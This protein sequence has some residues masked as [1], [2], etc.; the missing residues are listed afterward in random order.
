MK[1]LMF[2]IG[3]GLKNTL[4]EILHKPSLIIAY[5]VM[6]LALIGMVVMCIAMPVERNASPEYAALT[7]GALRVVTLALLLWFIY[8]GTK[9]GTTLFSMADVN[10]LFTSPVPSKSILI[11]GLLQ[12]AGA[13]LLVGALMLFNLVNFQNLLGIGPGQALA[14]IAVAIVYLFLMQLVQMLVYI[15]SATH[16][17]MRRVFRGAIN[18]ALLAVVLLAGWEVYAKGDLTAGLMGALASPVFGLIPVSG[19]FG[20]VA[21]LAVAGWGMEFYLNLG[22]SALAMAVL[23]YLLCS[24]QGDYYEDVLQATE[25]V[26]AVKQLQKAGK[27][28]SVAATS[29]ARRGKERLFGQGS[30]ALLARHWVEIRRRGILLI[31]KMTLTGVGGTI[32]FVIV[33]KSAG[34]ADEAGMIPFVFFMAYMMYFLGM[35]GFWQQE[36]TRPYI[37]LI[38]QS[39]A[40]RVLAATAMN[41]VKMGLDGAIAMIAAGLIVQ[42]DPVEVIL[43]CLCMFAFAAL[44]T[45]LDVL[46]RR[47]VGK[48]HANSLWMLFYM[49]ALLIGVAPVVTLFIIGYALAGVFLAYPLMLLA[50]LALAAL[51]L[52]LGKGVME[53]V[54]MD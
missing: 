8:R 33:A 3:R 28:Q 41:V 49:L 24:V 18:L 44:Y 22:L 13:M 45:Y 20:N 4:K 34:F 43:C 16:P 26:H 46:L 39:S 27:A 14:V 38:P 11:Y 32:F 25:K 10:L 23:I 40:S 6:V 12:Q 9:E 35:T 48:R 29:K 47:I 50:T 19:W 37:F 5:G 7:M 54:E 36:L 42:A 21:A 30:M 53:R 52:L 2:L 17:R 1:S 31:D 15:V 51:C